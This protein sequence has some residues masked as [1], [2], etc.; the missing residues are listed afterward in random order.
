MVQYKNSVW[1]HLHSKIMF[2]DN[3][4]GDSNHVDGTPQDVC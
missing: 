1:Q 4:Q 3:A 2:M